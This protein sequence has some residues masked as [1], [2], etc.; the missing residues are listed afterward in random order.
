[1]HSESGVTRDRV[2]ANLE[3][4]GYNF[5]VID[6]GGIYFYHDE[7]EK[8]SEGMINIRKQVEIAVEA[9]EVILFATDI[10]AGS[11]ALD[12][13]ISAMLRRSGKKVLLVMNKSDNDNIERESEKFARLGWDDS[14]AVSCAH[15]RGF[16]EMLGQ[17]VSMLPEKVP[18]P[19]KEKLKIAGLNSFLSPMRMY[20][21]NLRERLLIIQNLPQMLNLLQ[22]R[23]LHLMAIQAVAL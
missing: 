9:A 10:T 18:A 15:R 4:D 21:Q 12:E 22:A 16:Q 5:Q 20:I 14:I 19:E 17:I 1:V 3:W 6:T 13:D 2:S 11:T 23:L 7:K 8:P